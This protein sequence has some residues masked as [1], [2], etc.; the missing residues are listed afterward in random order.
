MAGPQK[1]VRDIYSVSGEDQ[2]L[3]GCIMK[4]L[5]LNII[6][7]LYIVHFVRLKPAGYRRSQYQ[8]EELQR[9]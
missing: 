3:L 5:Y 8:K 7:F 1:V 4:W 9:A 6:Y 2:G